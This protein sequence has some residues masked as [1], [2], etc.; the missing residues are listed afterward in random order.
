MIL[1]KTYTAPVINSDE[2]ADIAWGIKS[3][4]PDFEHLTDYDFENINFDE[5]QNG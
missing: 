1:P 3:E 5:E 2:D 4:K